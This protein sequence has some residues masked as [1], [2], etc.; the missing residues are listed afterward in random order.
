MTK[1]EENQR[2]GSISFHQDN[3][4]SRTWAKVH[5]GSPVLKACRKGAEQQDFCWSWWVI[6]ERRICPIPYLQKLHHRVVFA[7]LST[8]K[9]EDKL[10]PFLLWTAELQEV[11][12]T[13]V[14]QVAQEVQHHPVEAKGTAER[15]SVPCRSHCTNS[16]KKRTK[17]STFVL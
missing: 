9:Y 2:K 13:V 14:T 15:H 5:M 10:T 7:K 8:V 16:Q 12:L 11:Q 4:P 6:T 17:Y 3:L 1:S